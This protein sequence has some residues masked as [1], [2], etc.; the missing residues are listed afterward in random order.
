LLFNKISA[1]AYAA[2][3]ILKKQIIMLR[4]PPAKL[5]FSIN[6]SAEWRN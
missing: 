6:M 3:E 1:A 4:Q 5:C 2:A